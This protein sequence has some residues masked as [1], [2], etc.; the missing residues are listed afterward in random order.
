MK[1]NCD[2]LTGDASLR[3]FYDQLGGFFAVPTIPV[4]FE[5]HFGKTFFFN[6]LVINV[7]MDGLKGRC[8][9]S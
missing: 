7:K 8:V 3:I 2:L 1:S 9:R 5:D 4:E 6:A